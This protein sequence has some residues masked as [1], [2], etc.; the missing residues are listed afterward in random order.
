[1]KIFLRSLL[2]SCISLLF[3]TLLLGI[4][5]PFF[6]FSVGQLFF[7]RQANGSLILNKN[8]QV[9]GSTLL[10]QNFT[11]PEYFHPRPSNAGDKG[12]DASNSSGSNLGP[13]SQKLLDL[14]KKRTPLYRSQNNLSL[15]ALIPSDAITS[16]ASGLDPHITVANAL[17]QAARIASSRG[18]PLSTIKKLIEDHTEG[19]I[20]GVPRINVLRINLALDAMKVG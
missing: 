8:R 3:F 14:L 17:F 6:L 1:M 13:T 4:V 16:S 11:K 20:L 5:Y 2:P 18:I 10:G 19:S 12:Y 7:S 9:V 15:G